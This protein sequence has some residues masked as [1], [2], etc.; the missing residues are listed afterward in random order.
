VQ[1]N[2]GRALKLEAPRMRKLNQECY[3][4]IILAFRDSPQTLISLTELTGLHFRTV[5]PML[6]SWHKKQ[7]IHVSQW[8]PDSLG[9][10]VVPEFVWGAGE[11][12][13]R[14]SAEDLLAA[15]VRRRALDRSRHRRKK[16][17]AGT[18]FASMVDALASAK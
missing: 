7:I 11:D 4:Q 5:T 2:R 3:A 17:A 9:R 12:A 18:V 6:S 8:L 1:G 15:K 13:P 10:K 14:M 16:Q